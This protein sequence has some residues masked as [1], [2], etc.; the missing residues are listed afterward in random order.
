MR[1][2]IFGFALVACTL[3]AMPGGA[4]AQNTALEGQ[5]IAADGMPWAG[6]DVVLVSTDTGERHT[7]KTGNDG[8]YS[9][10]GLRPGVYKI[11]L[12][13]ENDKTFEYSET[14]TLRGKVPNDVSVNFSTASGSAASALARAP[15]EENAARFAAVKLHFNKGLGAMDDAKLLRAQTAAADRTKIN[16][17]YQMAIAE[18][19]LAERADPR[20][21]A[22]TR[23]M[24]E[25][26][27]GEAHDFA[28]DGDGAIAAYE[29][30]I[31]LA[32]D[33]VEFLNLGRLQAERAKFADADGS[34]EKAAALDAAVGREVLEECRE[35][36]E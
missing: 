35:S 6:L 21:D 31:E 16:S 4:Q 1:V 30:A 8:R 36:F 34:C 17:D 20:M 10:F 19:E 32:P 28:G 5:V 3:L 12:V 9:L 7:L 13:D 26:H 27:I 14:R 33:A 15:D 25:A 22:K 2:S 23:A 18:F 29:K 24:I 11:S